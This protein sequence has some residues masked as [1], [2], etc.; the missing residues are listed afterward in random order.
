MA[1]IKVSFIHH[2]ARVAECRPTRPEEQA[3]MLPNMRKAEK[4][5]RERSPVSIEV[6]TGD[7]AGAHL[8]TPGLS[9]DGFHAVPA[10]ERERWPR[11]RSPCVSRT[12]RSRSSSPQIDETVT[13]SRQVLVID[14]STDKEAL[15]RK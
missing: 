15:F 1:Q 4:C 5:E 11:T 14:Y 13:P 8:A 12:T 2:G 7:R 6:D 10:P 3:K 9:R